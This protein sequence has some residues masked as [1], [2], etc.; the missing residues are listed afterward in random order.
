MLKIIRFTAS[1]CQPCK[2]LAPI[3]DQLQLENSNIL[4]ETID[5][6]QNKEITSNYKVTS[7][8]T[9]VF[10]KN[11]TEVTRFTGVKPKTAIQSLINPLK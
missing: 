6:D 7:V 1:W 2:A 8:P 9:I 10:V 5:V 4:F 3:L 11:G